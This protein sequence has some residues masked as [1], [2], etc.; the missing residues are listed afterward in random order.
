[1]EQPLSVCGAT[2][3]APCDDGRPHV[4]RVCNR[5]PHADRWHREKRGGA[6][7]AESSGDAGPI[8]D[9]P[10]CVHTEPTP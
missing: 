2:D 1:M 10:R 6:L 5:P 3:W 4:Y 7:W 8:P 9:G